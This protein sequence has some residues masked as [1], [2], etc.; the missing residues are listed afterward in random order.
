MDLSLSKLQE[1]AKD[2]KAWRAAVHGVTMSRTQLSDSTTVR[3]YSLLLRQTLLS[4]PPRAL[5][6]DFCFFSSFFYH[7]KILSQYWRTSWISSFSFALSPSLVLSF[8]PIYMCAVLVT[9]ACLILWNPMDSS[10]PGSS[11][12]GDSPGKNTGGVAMPSSNGSFQPR[13]QTQVFCTAGRFFTKFISLTYVSSLKDIFEIF[14]IL[15][16]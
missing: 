16:K 5:W 7:F 12:H 6:I 4:I 13:E 1:L 14:N 11:V 15:F 8:V 9:Q 10:P 3:N 2:R